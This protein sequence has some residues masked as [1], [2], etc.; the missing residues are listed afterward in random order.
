VGT[1]L[2]P[3]LGSAADAAG[4]ETLASVVARCG[5][6]GRTIPATVARGIVLQLLGALHDV[7]A[8]AGESS[9]TRLDLTGPRPASAPRLDAFL[10]DRHGRVSI[11]RAEWARLG[12]AADIHEVGAVLHALLA[13]GLEPP[14]RGRLDAARVDVDVVL[15]ETIAR[16]CH[17][18][19]DARFDSFARFA[20]VLA[21]TGACAG[22]IQIAAWLRPPAPTSRPSTPPS[23]WAHTGTIVM[24]SP[25]SYMVAP[26]TRRPDAVAHA[27]KRTGAIA[28]SALGAGVAALVACAGTYFYLA[29]LPL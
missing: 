22:E 21:R 19:P 14:A 6:E 20:A 11:D 23:M 26:S 4:Y 12:K 5:A 9:I 13:C 15:V 18:D 25:P 7:Y 2:F 8:W 16:A 10:L 3:L 29:G 1:A 27:R 28:L 24:S 17:A